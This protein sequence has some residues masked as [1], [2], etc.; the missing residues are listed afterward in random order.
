M[1]RRLFFK[2]TF[3]IAGVIGV[4]TPALAARPPSLPATYVYLELLPNYRVPMALKASKP[5]RDGE[6]AKVISEEWKK[7]IQVKN[8]RSGKPVKLFD[9]NILLRLQCETA[10]GAAPARPS[11]EISN[12]GKQV[13]HVHLTLLD[14]LEVTDADQTKNDPAKK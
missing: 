7:E 8:E 1:M 13:E 5:C 12:S 11:F 4:S 6:K 2:T 10:K 3:L 14:G 9:R